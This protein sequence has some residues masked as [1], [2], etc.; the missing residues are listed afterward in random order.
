[1]DH[2]AEFRSPNFHGWGQRCFVAILVLTLVAAKQR[3]AQMRVSHWLVLLLSAAGGVYAARN[4]PISAMLLVLIVGPGL[5]ARV[6]DLGERPSAWQPLRRFA[7]RISEFS[8]RAQA[9]E[10]QW[11]GHL[12]PV[13]GVLAGLA[14]CVA[15]G[16]L[17]SLQLVNAQFDAK[18]L[19]AGAVD[20]L[21]RDGGPEPIFGPD[22]WG[23]YF[24]YRLY[25]RRQVVIDDRHDLYGSD[26]FR[27]YLMMIQ[28]EP[29]WAD[30]LKKW[31]VR[32]MVLPSDST[33]AN[34]VRKT[35]SD[36]QVAYEDKVA[37]VMEKKP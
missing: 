15:G 8:A 13:A 19:P 20:Y 1:M 6:T 24:I 2:I 23:G 10:F 25:P 30:L 12:W 21:A 16:R 11:R 3:R 17:G 9:Q 22:Q 34:L 4:L 31:R 35:Q 26:R 29:G 18:Y 37:V 5:W 14:I 36:W 27:E 33:L 28:V 7:Q 32:V